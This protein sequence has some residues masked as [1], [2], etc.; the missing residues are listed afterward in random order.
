MELVRSPQWHNVHRGQ[1]SWIAHKKCLQRCFC[2]TAIA[3]GFDAFPL[4]HWSFVVILSPGSQ[5]PRHYLH[6]HIIQLCD[7]LSCILGYWLHID[8]AYTVVLTFFLPIVIAASE[9]KSFPRPVLRL[10][11]ELSPL[12]HSSKTTMSPNS[13]MMEVPRKLWEH[14]TPKSTEMWKFMQG[15]NKKRNSNMQVSFALQSTHLQVQ[16]STISS[17][18]TKFFSSDT[19]CVTPHDISSML[20]VR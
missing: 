13:T 19:P 14:A 10:Q 8:S 20:F 2:V 12:H 16:A 18:H 4:F 15:V 17:C 1:T 9:V 7:I 6:P 11:F 3:F 5:L